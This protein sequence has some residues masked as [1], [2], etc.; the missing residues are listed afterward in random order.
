[1]IRAKFRPRSSSKAIAENT[2]GSWFEPVVYALNA[3]PRVGDHVA[4][5]EDPDDEETLSVHE[6][7]WEAPRGKQDYEVTVVLK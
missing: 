5:G 1:M 3:V 4:I 6:V 7:I 2:G